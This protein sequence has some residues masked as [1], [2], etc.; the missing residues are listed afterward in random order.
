MEK[1]SISAVG[2][3]HLRHFRRIGIVEY[4]AVEHRI[5]NVAG[6]SG[7]NHGYAHEVARFD[8]ASVA[9][10]TK[11][12]Y[13]Q[14]YSHYTEQ[15][16]EQL[17]SHLHSECHTVIFNKIYLEPIGHMD[18][19]TQKHVGFDPYLHQLVDNQNGGDDNRDKPAPG[20]FH[21]VIMLYF[22]LPSLA[23]TLKVAWGTAIRRS[24]GISFPV[25]RQMP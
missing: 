4:H 10:P 2:R 5:D 8:I 16:Q 7:G 6:G 20:Q 21:S 24:L 13:Q 15:G 22:R 23:S 9:Y 25:S 14:S 17:A 1:R 11:I 3:K 19:L 18:V 12:V